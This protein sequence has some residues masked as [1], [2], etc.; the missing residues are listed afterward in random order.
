MSH[1]G[2]VKSF[3]LSRL[4]AGDGSYAEDLTQDT[5]LQGLHSRGQIARIGTLKTWLCRIALNKVYDRHRKETGGGKRRYVSLDSSGIGSTDD[6]PLP[7]D[8]SVGGENEQ[9]KAIDIALLKKYVERLPPAHREPLLLY[10]F[11]GLSTLEIAR[12]LHMNVNALKVQLFRGRNGLRDEMK[13][14]QTRGKF[15]NTNDKNA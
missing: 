7:M 1:Y 8:I 12:R 10:Y 2:A 4:Y 3:I 13:K 11:E 5:I 14:H 15:A 9:I 6:K